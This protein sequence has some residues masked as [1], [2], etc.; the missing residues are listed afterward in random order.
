M[1]F[2]DRIWIRRFAL[3][4]IGIALVA[5]LTVGIA[6]SQTNGAPSGSYV[7]ELGNHEVT[8][9]LRIRADGSL[10]ATLDNL[11]PSAPWMFVAADLHLDGDN[12]SFSVP[13][14][15]AIWKGTFVRGGETLQGQWFQKGQSWFVSFQHQQFVPAT[16]P[17]AVDGIWLGVEPVAANTTTRV[18]IVFRSDASGREYC[19]MDALDVYYMDLECANV[20]L[21]GSD[22]SFDIPVAGSHWTGTLGKDGDSLNGIT[23]VKVAEDASTRIVS[24]PLI[25][26]RQA[27][28]TP[29][30]AKPGIAYDSA[31]PP[32]S[33][34][35][36]ERVLNNDLAGA[37]KNGELAPVTGAGVSIAVYSHGVSR[38][39][40]IGAARPDSIFEIGSMTK[41]FTGLLLAQMTK[42]GKV[43]LDEPVRELLPHGTVTKPQGSE[44]TLLDLASQ[45]SGLPPMPDN[46]SVANMDDPYAD[47][48]PAELYS[49]LSRRGFVNP[50]RTPSEFGSLG[51]GL[52]GVALANRSGVPLSRLIEEEITAPLG[53]T[54]TVLSLSAEQ[55]KRL[56]PG[57]DEFHGPAKAWRS[58]A[59]AGAI[60]LRSTADDMLKLLVANLHP[61]QLNAA[62]PSPEEST[63][64]GAIRISLEPR[65]EL[66]SGMGLTLGWL[67]DA[68]TGNYWHNG[69]TAAYS[70]YA[71]F[72][73]KG[74]YAAV[75]LLNTS[76]GVNGSFVENLGRHVRQRLA[77]EPA[78]SLGH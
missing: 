59:L 53:M 55:E 42:Q 10:S 8:L 25:L 4:Q 45:R 68:K 47:Y 15:Q 30:P 75:I 33:A 23:T 22:L 52:L 26:T 46:I 7:G 44:I 65:G 16:K 48:H 28:L 2:C 50:S 13:S 56:L 43:T 62:V 17:S 20:L 18:Q 77:G 66:S 27:A 9:H 58:D 51:F 31:L 19:T 73:P 24:Y 74:D 38:V 12:L 21:K 39:F 78:L 6:S 32:I 60:G 36:I 41:T 72:N 29:E 57:H 67:Y 35:E 49:Y 54:D 71:F 69:A 37:L 70:S 5:L 11:D 1:H 3:C 64:P 34:E 76:P 63:L 61:E 40:S 14:I